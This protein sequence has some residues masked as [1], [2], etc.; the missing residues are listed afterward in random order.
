MKL[1]FSKIL[2]LIVCPNDGHSVPDILTYSYKYITNY[3]F[4]L[5]SRQFEVWMTLTDVFIILSME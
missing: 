4:Y 1:G 2:L 5:I 3:K